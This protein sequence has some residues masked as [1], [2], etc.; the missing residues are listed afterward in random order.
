MSETAF[1][2]LIGLLFAL[3]FVGVCWASK[4]MA[5]ISRETREI[6]DRSHELRMN[7]FRADMAEIRRRERLGVWADYWT[8]LRDNAPQ[9]P[10][11][12]GT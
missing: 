5:K 3:A 12:E 1:F 2:W 6:Q 8:T 4:E 11:Q 10:T 7:L 9:P